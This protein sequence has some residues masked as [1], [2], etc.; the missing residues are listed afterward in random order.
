LALGINKM[1][2]LYSAVNYLKSWFVSQNIQLNANKIN[3]SMAKLIHTLKYQ[4]I[5]TQNECKTL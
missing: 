3:V 5:S 4:Q 1:G 2:L